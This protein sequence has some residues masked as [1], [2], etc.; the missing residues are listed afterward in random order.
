MRTFV[1][2]RG[3][4]ER[5]YFRMSRLPLSKCLLR[6]CGDDDFPFVSFREPGI[7]DENAGSLG[8]AARL[9]RL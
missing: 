8:L 6:A 3:L 4:D 2:S 9:W 5:E 1:I 7:R